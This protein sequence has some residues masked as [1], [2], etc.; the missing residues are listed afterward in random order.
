MPN[1]TSPSGRGPVRLDDAFRREL[2]VDISVDGAT[3]SAFPGEPLSAALLA[4]GILRF[5]DSPR[6]GTPRGPFCLM[7][8]CQECIVEIDGRLAPAC[9]ELVRGGMAVRLGMNG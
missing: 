9:Q 3:I 2:P 7:G 6:A 8:I 5:R 4:A 1:S